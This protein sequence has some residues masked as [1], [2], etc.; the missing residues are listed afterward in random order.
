MWGHGKENTTDFNDFRIRNVI[1]VRNV[2]RFLY[3]E[4]DFRKE[5]DCIETLPYWLN[6]NL[7]HMNQMLDSLQTSCN[8]YCNTNYWSAMAVSIPEKSQTP[9]KEERAVVPCHRKSVFKKY[10]RSS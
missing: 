1:F 4:Y 3:Q 6:R 5:I 10:V 7:Y 8:N 2:S 9:E